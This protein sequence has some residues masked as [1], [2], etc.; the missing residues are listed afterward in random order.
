MVLDLR[1][2]PAVGLMVYSCYLGI[3]TTILNTGP[4]I[5]LYKSKTNGARVTQNQDQE[6]I[7]HICGDCGFPGKRRSSLAPCSVS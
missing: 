2:R 3:P 7:A 6:Q 5:L 1:F 4:S